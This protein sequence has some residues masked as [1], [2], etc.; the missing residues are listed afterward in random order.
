[1]YECGICVA[2]FSRKHDMERHRRTHTG[3][4]PYG[5]S[6]YSI[7]TL[8][9]TSTEMVMENATDVEPCLLEAMAVDV[10]SNCNRNVK[11][12]ITRRLKASR[13]EKG[14]WLLRVAMG[15]PRVKLECQ[16]HVE[17][18]SEVT[19]SGDLFLWSRGRFL[20]SLVSGRG[21]IL[22]SRLYGH[23]PILNILSVLDFS[24]IICQTR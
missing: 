19:A 22:S 15:L 1:M 18:L 24:I 14:L 5:K 23:R 20:S 11:P 8:A 17:V 4:S 7:S 10:T 2:S 13:N 9:R 12:P 3:E 21:C 6:P 16:H